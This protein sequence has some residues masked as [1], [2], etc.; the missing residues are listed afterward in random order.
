[1]S[2]Q[3]R[4]FNMSD[5][6]KATN[7]TLKDG[8]TSGDP[9]KVIKGSE[10]D[11]EFDLIASAVASKANINSPTFTGTP[12]LPSGTVATTCIFNF[13]ITLYFFKKAFCLN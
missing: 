2:K 13:F 4:E 8:L 10:I 12:T 1:M 9:G 3:V 5:Y 7:F 6:T 11:D